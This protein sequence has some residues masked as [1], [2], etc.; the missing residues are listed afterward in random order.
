MQ[1]QPKP[2]WVA[3]GRATGKRVALLGAALASL[4]RAP[5][6]AGAKL[7]QQNP[8][9]PQP[10]GFAA[11]ITP[12]RTAGQTFTAGQTGAL[13]RV[14]VFLERDFGEPVPN[15][16]I[17]LEVDSTSAAGTPRTDRPPLASSSLPIAALTQAQGFV[18]FR[19]THPAPVTQGTV[20]AII[21]HSDVPLGELA[22]IWD[23]SPRADPYPRGGNAQRATDAGPWTVVPQQDLYFQT[24]VV[25]SRPHRRGL[26]HAAG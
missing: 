15:G 1:R 9:D 2:G 21:L 24:F 18:G 13:E 8:F 3:Q 10:G 19:L 4:G 6:L 26:A 12:T 16:T 5:A 11:S 22:I 25:G 17:F 14:A 20:Y 7:D 23:G